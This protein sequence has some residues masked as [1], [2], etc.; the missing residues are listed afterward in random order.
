[1]PKKGTRTTTSFAAQRCEPL[2]TQN[3]FTLGVESQ[4]FPLRPLLSWKLIQHI[5]GQLQTARR[6]SDHSR[7]SRANNHAPE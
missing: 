1:M 6:D 2:N 3:D 4:P 7:R 5:Q